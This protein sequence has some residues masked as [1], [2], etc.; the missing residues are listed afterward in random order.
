MLLSSLSLFRKPFLLLHKNNHIHHPQEIKM[1]NTLSAAAISLCYLFSSSS[2]VQA[3]KPITTA[4]G[5]DA[6]DELIA[7][8]TKDAKSYFVHKSV[9][10]PHDDKKHRG[11]EDAAAT[12]DQW[13]VGE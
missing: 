8:T 5:R 13:L 4:V 1:K 7:K 9:I 3:D 6:P 10:I 11:G 12:S 2:V